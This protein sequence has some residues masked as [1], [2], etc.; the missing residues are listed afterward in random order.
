[1]A[2]QPNVA[3]ILETATCDDSPKKKDVS[4]VT[5]VGAGPAITIADRSMITD[6]R[7]VNLLVETAQENHI[8]FQFKQPL[9]GS[10]DAGHIHISREGVPSAVV[11]MPTRYLHSPVGVL[12]I[13]DFDHTI[14]LVTKTLPR[15]AKGLANL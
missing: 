15:L 8:P 11:S 1:Y 12:S 10:T 4:P 7:L 14:A 2:I 3:F 5:R 13:K 6:R 9:N